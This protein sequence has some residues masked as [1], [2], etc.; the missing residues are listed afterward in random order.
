MDLMELRKLVQ[1]MLRADLSELELDDTKR[2]LRV[3]LKRDNGRRGPEVP[4]VVQV[5]PSVVPSVVPGPAA[6]LAATAAAPAPAAEGPPPGTEV[7]K[8]PIVGTFYRASSPEAEPFVSPGKE[9]AEGA[10]L[11]IIEAMKVMNEIR[12]EFRGQVLEVLAENGEPVEFGQ[13][14]FLIKKS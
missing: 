11:C 9:F 7:F 5:V 1:L 13:P 3:H 12:A 8:S 10:V 14:L 6:V 2:G 4:G